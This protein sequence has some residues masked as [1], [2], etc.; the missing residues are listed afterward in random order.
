MGVIVCVLVPLASWLS[1]PSPGYTMFAGYTDFRLECSVWEGAAA[2]PVSPTALLPHASG[3]LGNLLGMGEAGGRARSVDA[4]RAHL[5]EVA[6]LGCELPRA[7]R[8]ELTLHETDEGGH[9]RVTRAARACP[10]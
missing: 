5:P 1:G 6:A 10:P 9:L 8:V 4:L 2:H 3:Y 7:T